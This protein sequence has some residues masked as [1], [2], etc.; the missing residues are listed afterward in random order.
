M[1]SRGR[2]TRLLRGTARYPLGRAVRPYRSTAYRG[3]SRRVGGYKKGGGGGYRKYNKTKKMVV[4]HGPTLLERIAS[5]I[6]GVGKVAQAVLPIIE[7]INTEAKYYDYSATSNCY[8][9]G[10]TDQI[11]CLTAAIAQGSNDSQRIG[12]SIL[13]RDISIKVQCWWSADATHT[14]N[15]G[16]FTMFVWKENAQDNA[17]TAAKLFETPSQLLSAFNKDYTDQFVII[18]D[19][20]LS[21]ETPW[22]PGGTVISGPRQFKIYKKIDW[23]LRYD[24]TSTS[25]QTQGHIYVI[26]RGAWPTSANQTTYNIYSR[27]NYTDN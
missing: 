27:F 25:D 12:N 21:W 22:I 13:G 6:G 26:M 17:P 19:K 3:T 16:R 2:F 5:G 10:T 11:V 14:Y 7:A 1:A 15:F 9:P 4:G 8:A 18:K 24:N 20:L 23:H